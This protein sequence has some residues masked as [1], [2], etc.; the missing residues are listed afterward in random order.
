MTSNASFFMS[1]KLSTRHFYYLIFEYKRSSWSGTL[2]EN[3]HVTLFLLHIFD[4]GTVNCSI[5]ITKTK[6]IQTEKLFTQKWE[7]SNACCFF[8][9]WKAQIPLNMILILWSCWRRPSNQ[10]KNRRFQI[11]RNRPIQVEIIPL[12]L[13]VIWVYCWTPKLLT[14]NAHLAI[15]IRRT[16]SATFYTHL[17]N[18]NKIFTVELLLF[19]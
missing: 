13:T 1:I 10:I 18:F 8:P 3:L 9:W 2:R 19:D 14:S 7:F 17:S 15:K 12:N 5:R 16:H 11:A 4:L 6:F